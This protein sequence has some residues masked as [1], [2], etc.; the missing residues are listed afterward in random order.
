MSAYFVGRQRRTR[1]LAFSSK[2]HFRKFA[3]RVSNFIQTEGLHNRR[4]TGMKHS[5]TAWPHAVSLADLR[6]ELSRAE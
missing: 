4:M 2:N 1:K 3:N 6:F 5:L